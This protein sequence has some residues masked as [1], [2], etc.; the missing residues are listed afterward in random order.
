M[1]DLKPER[2]ERLWR[3]AGL[4]EYFL[5]NGGTNSKLYKFVESCISDL[6]AS[7]GAASPAGETAKPPMPRRGPGGHYAEYLSTHIHTR[8]ECSTCIQIEKWIAEGKY[9][10][11]AAL[12]PERCPTCG[13]DDR[14]D[15]GGKR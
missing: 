5:G 10:S 13:S 7:G 8:S 6:G 3:E 9:E 2:I 15:D 14:C 11:D 1:S 12:S 4:P